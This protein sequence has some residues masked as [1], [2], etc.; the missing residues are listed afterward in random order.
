M[1]KSAVRSRASPGDR[2]VQPLTT[3]NE[4][5]GPENEAEHG[6]LGCVV[7]M[8]FL[9][10]LGELVQMNVCSG[11]ARQTTRRWENNAPFS[12]YNVRLDNTRG[13]QVQY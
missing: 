13:Q 6:A 2:T 12:K 4:V 10:L 1:R 7:M 8:M 3:S 5:S 9:V 11:I